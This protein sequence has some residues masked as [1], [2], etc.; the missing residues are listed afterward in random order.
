MKINSDHAA[1]ENLRALIADIRR[2]T[3]RAPFPPASKPLPGVDDDRLMCAVQSL[4]YDFR[5]KTGHLRLEDGHCTD[6]TG[7]IRF[8]EQIDPAVETV[9]TWSG[10]RRDTSYQRSERGDWTAQAAGRPE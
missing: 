6:A 5:S 9:V 10:T 1:R 2:K 4:T 8:F 3:F 7:C